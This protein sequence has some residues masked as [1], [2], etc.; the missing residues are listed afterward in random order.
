[1][2]KNNEI[3]NKLILEYD[4]KIKEFHQD[5]DN[6]NKKIQLLNQDIENYKLKL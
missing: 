5:Q 4:I 2:I 1:M 3:N 6:Y